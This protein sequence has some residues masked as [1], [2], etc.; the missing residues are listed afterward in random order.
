M[1]LGGFVNAH[2][3]ECLCYWE[4]RRSLRLRGD[5]SRKRLHA[6]ALQTCGEL[7]CGWEAELRGGFAYED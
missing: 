5:R 2:R 4:A 7:R 3:Q 1:G 6:T